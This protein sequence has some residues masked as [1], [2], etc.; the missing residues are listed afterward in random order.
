ML[1]RCA[2]KAFNFMKLFE[3][4]LA[5]EFAESEFAEIR[6]LNFQHLIVLFC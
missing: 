6:H 3:N 2:T 4:M 1:S 5:T